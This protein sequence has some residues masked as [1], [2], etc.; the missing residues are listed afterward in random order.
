MVL[1][2]EIQKI[3]VVM[4]IQLPQLL[5][6]LVQSFV[7]AHFLKKMV[8]EMHPVQVQVE[9]VNTFQVVAQPLT[10][11]VLHKDSNLIKS[12]FKGEETPPFLYLSKWC[13]LSTCANFS[14]KK[15]LH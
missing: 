15:D 1:Y 2:Q 10:T 7:L 12:Y 6:L 13:K 14:I 9:H 4:F 5:V 3:L 11:S 8:P